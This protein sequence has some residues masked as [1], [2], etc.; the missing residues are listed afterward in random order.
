MRKISGD[1][2][3]IDKLLGGDDAIVFN[4]I[5]M[6]R[7]IE[8]AVIWTD[9]TSYL[10]VR[11]NPAA[12]IWLYVNEQADKNTEEDL[13][14]ILSDFIRNDRNAHVVAQ[15]DFIQTVFRRLSADTGVSFSEYM[16][17]N[18]YACHSVKRVKAVG[19]LVPPEPKYKG[20]MAVLIKQ[21][22][23]DAENRSISDME[24]EEIAGALEHSD[25]LFLWKD[26]D[27]VAMANI[28]HKNETHA[29]INT[30]VTDRAYREKGYAK[31]LVGEL[32]QKILS[33]HLTPLLYADARNPISNA[34]YQDIGYEKVGEV[35]EFEVN[36]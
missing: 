30:V 24:A 32:S 29:R 12:P 27:I 13:Y 28:A 2:A 7:Y 16:P 18:V 8:D 11:G 17:M 20:R 10:V 21:M 3:I 31:M 22:A 25:R 15:S 6:I 5:S 4:L 35:T 9:D 26:S 23:E 14:Q 1:D 36:N 33:S 19:A 34:V